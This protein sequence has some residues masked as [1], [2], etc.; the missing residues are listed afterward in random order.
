MN[1]ISVSTH[2]VEFG[3][4]VVL[5]NVPSP[6]TTLDTETCHEDLISKNVKVLLERGI[7]LIVSESTSRGMPPSII[8]PTSPSLYGV[9]S[10]KRFSSIKP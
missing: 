10:E 8:S 7:H 3:A 2:A 6:T 5:T 1:G 4:M 9:A